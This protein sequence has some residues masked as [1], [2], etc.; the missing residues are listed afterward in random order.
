[1]TFEAR[2]SV[3]SSL[4]LCS[5][6]KH[7]LWAKPAS[8]H[9]MWTLKQPMERPCGNARKHP[10][11]SQCQLTSLVP[12]SPQKHVLQPSQAFG[13]LKPP[14]RPWAKTTQLSC[15]KIFDLKEHE[16]GKYLLLFCYTIWICSLEAG[17][18]T[19]V[20]SVIW[21]F[22]ALTTSSERSPLFMANWVQLLQHQIIPLSNPVGKTR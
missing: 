1:M 20:L 22:S 8:C 9:D 2:S 10:C 12:E 11:H 3:T 7:S 19:E 16:D 5:L 17:V 4:L 14:E 15:S 13:C 18:I 6:L 21:L